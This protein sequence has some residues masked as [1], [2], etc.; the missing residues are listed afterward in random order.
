MRAAVLGA[1]DGIVSTASLIVGVAMASSSQ[2]TLIIAGVAALVAGAMSMAAGEFVS[3]S[4]QSDTETA[5]LAKER[6]ELVEETESEQDELTRIYVMRGLDAPLARTVAL[7][8][9]DHDALGAHARDELGIHE[10]NTAK[11]MQAAFAS[12]ASFATGAALPLLVVIVAPS[13]VLIPCTVTA[14]LVFLA[15]LGVI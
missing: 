15:F 7:K 8:L 10:M 1:N 12:A 14:S 9:M 5:D 3:V 13:A 6:R 11:P 4:A 2:Q